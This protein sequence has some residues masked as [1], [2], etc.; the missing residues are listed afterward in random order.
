ME[1]YHNAVSDKLVVVLFENLTIYQ[2][3]KKDNLLKWK[4]VIH[5]QV[6][7]EQLKD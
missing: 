4:T 7:P 5:G 3:F 2:V 1:S 6:I